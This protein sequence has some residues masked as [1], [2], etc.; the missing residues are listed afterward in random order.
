MNPDRETLAYLARHVHTLHT[1][2]L[3]E[4]S[5]Q[6]GNYQLATSSIYPGVETAFENLDSQLDQTITELS[7]ARNLLNQIMEG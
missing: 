2:V 5:A 1:K 6:L 7:K 4:L 3:P